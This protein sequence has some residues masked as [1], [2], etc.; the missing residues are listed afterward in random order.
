MLKKFSYLQK[1]HIDQFNF[2]IMTLCDINNQTLE[3]KI[4]VSYLCAFKRVPIEISKQYY[5]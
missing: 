1:L 2:G 4:K 5:S 3:K